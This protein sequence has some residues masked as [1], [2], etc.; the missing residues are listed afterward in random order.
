MSIQFFYVTLIPIKST[1]FI[2]LI[3]QNELSNCFTYKTW[4][5]FMLVQ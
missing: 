3:E 1:F 2:Q 5:S 4:Q